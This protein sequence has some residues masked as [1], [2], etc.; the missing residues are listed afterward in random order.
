M[1]KQNNQYIM[2][3][4][5]LKDRIWSQKYCLSKRNCYLSGES[6][7]F[8][9]CYLGRKTIKNIANSHYQNDDIWISK[10]QYSDILKQEMV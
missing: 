6:L 4:S 10:K 5:I 2:I 3:W 9:R 7:K 1:L 8:K